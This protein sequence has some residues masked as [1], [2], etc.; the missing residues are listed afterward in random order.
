MWTFI[1]TENVEPTNNIAERAIRPAV[2]LR[3]TSLGTQGERGSRLVERM[4]TISVTLKK[5][6]RSLHGFIGEVTHTV[7]PGATLP[8]QLG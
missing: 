1:E 5:T 3:K 6:G 8:K 4:Q 7:L 2:I